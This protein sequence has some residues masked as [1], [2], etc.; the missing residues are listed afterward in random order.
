MIEDFCQRQY[1]LIESHH[2]LSLIIY[3]AVQT[4]FYKIIQ[5][6]RRHYVHEPLV[7]LCLRLLGR[8]DCPG[9]E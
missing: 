1:T 9:A 7:F 2:Y 3:Q 6:R 4:H 8:G 5:T